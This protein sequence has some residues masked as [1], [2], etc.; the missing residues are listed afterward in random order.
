MSYTQSQ[1]KA[2]RGSSISIGPATGSPPTATL[3]GEMTD[4]PFSAPKW[5]TVDV[6]NMEY[7]SDSESLVTMRKPSSFTVKCN[8]VASDAGQVAV[9][10]AHSAGTLSPFTIVLNSGETITFNAYVLSYDLPA[11][12]TKEIDFSFDLQTSGAVTMTVAS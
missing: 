2:G 1:A 10:A 11:E 5:D 9:I 4:L 12:V 6:S 8:R 3:I 7:G